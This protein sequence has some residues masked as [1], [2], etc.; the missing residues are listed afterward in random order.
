MELAAI[1]VGK[2]QFNYFNEGCERKRERERKFNSTADLFSP[3]N[4]SLNLGYFLFFLVRFQQR[5]QRLLS[6]RERAEIFFWSINEDDFDADKSS[7]KKLNLGRKITRIKKRNWIILA[8]STLQYWTSLW[9]FSQL[10]LRLFFAA[11]HLMYSHA[12]W[13][14]F[15]WSHHFS[16]MMMKICFI[17]KEKFYFYAKMRKKIKAQK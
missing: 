2:K 7:A 16:S 10:I 11:P 14:S 12:K 1:A 15:N 3:V 8:H 5:K 13:C 6:E 9:D 4:R 17:E